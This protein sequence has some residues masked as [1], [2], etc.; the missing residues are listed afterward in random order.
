MVATVIEIIQN[1]LTIII[2]IFSIGLCVL[3]DRHNKKR[4]L[5]IEYT[6]KLSQCYNKEGGLDEEKYNKLR[7][8]IKYKHIP[9]HYKA[10]KERNKI[11]KNQSQKIF[12]ECCDNEGNLDEKKYN[13]RMKAFYRRRRSSSIDTHFGDLGSDF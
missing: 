10:T 11:I 12:R 8:E 2:T 13:K 9:C 6:T 3:F 1:N 7:Q 4:R 5:Q